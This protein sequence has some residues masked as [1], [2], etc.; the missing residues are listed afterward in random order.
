MRV[1]KIIILILL[2]CCFIEVG[3]GARFFGQLQVILFK[4]ALTNN[5]LTNLFLLIMII[6]Q[7]AIVISI[8]SQNKVTDIG[9]L[10][11]IT[12]LTLVIILATIHAIDSLFINCI[13][14]I[15]STIYFVKFINRKINAPYEMER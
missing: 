9:A 3:K 5:I 8:I 2:Q 13:Y 4:Y 15:A 1:L 12:I 14:L 7:L 10:V 6:S 11:G